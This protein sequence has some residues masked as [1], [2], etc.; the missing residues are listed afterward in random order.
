MPDSLLPISKIIVTK[1]GNLPAIIVGID[2]TDCISYLCYVP[3]KKL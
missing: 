1:Q 3:T 2:E